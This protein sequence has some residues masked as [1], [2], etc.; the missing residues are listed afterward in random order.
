MNA[1]DRG[2]PAA[3]LYTPPATSTPEAPTTTGSTPRRSAFRPVGTGPATAPTPTAPPATTA[4]PTHT[5]P[6]AASAPPVTRTPSPAPTSAPVPAVP[7]PSNYQWTP[8]PVATPET[9]PSGVAGALSVGTEKVK[10]FAVRAKKSLTEGDDLTASAKRGGPRKARVLV[11]RVDP[12]S[13]LK[14]GFLLSIALGIMVVIAVYII[15][16]TLNGLGLFAL[17]NSW[18][19]RLFDGQQVFN[20]QELLELNKVMSATILISVV[21]VV[22]ITALTTIAAFLYNTVSSVVGG[23][24]VTLTDD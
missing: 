18:I 3:G 2:A 7:A 12:W 11:S 1:D 20:V 5:A 22:L 8:N 4:L 21:N 24:Y 10:G 13:V 15:W 14:I 23:I 9:E 19:E 16:N 6:V 17:V